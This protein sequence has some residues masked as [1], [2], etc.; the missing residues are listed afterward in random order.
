MVLKVANYALV[1]RLN[2]RRGISWKEL[3]SNVGVALE[4]LVSATVIN[5]EENVAF[6]ELHLQVEVV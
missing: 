1:A 4:G 3:Q 2:K 6:L 5:K